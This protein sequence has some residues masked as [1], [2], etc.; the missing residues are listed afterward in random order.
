MP[1]GGCVGVIA[2][3]VIA[4]VFRGLPAEAGKSLDDGARVALEEFCAE[5]S[6]RLR[7]WFDSSRSGETKNKKG[8][9]N[10][11][12]FG[13]AS[14]AGALL[15]VYVQAQ[16]ILE[17]CHDR[18][19]LYS[20]HEKPYL[21]D[22]APPI[23][24]VVRAILEIGDHETLAIMP[25]LGKWTMMMML[26]TVSLAIPWV[27]YNLKCWIDSVALHVVTQWAILQP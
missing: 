3:A 8:G 25:H 19:E 4:T 26:N 18:K 9:S 10:D 17:I 2:N 22:D 11:A 12:G 20:F 13:D 23:L 1:W 24:D 6:G 21:G 27:T 14:I 5:I 15:S 7:D 16:A